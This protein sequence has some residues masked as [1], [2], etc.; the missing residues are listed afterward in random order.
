MLQMLVGVEQPSMWQLTVGLILAPAV[1]FPSWPC[2]VTQWN[3]K[4]NA[5]LAISSGTSSGGNCSMHFLDT[6]PN[7]SM[8]ATSSSSVSLCEWSAR[9]GELAMQR[10]RRV[11][12]DD[13]DANRAVWVLQIDGVPHLDVSGG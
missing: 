10:N 12:E 8:G 7:M 6:L 4:S 2:S 9:I 5:C 11:Q 1:N 13:T 3:S